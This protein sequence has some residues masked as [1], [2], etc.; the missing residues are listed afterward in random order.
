MQNRLLFTTQKP[1]AIAPETSGGIRRLYTLSLTAKTRSQSRKE[2]FMKNNEP[3][4]VLSAMAAFVRPELK[5]LPTS[6][7]SPI[8]LLAK[9]SQTT[10]R[11]H[12]RLLH[13]TRT[14][15]NANPLNNGQKLDLP[16]PTTPEPSGGLATPTP[17]RIP[18]SRNSYPVGKPRRWTDL[19]RRS[20]TS[21]P[22]S[23]DLPRLG[24]DEAAAQ[25]W[26]HATSNPSPTHR[27]GIT[28]WIPVPNKST[29]LEPISLSASDVCVEAVSCVMDGIPESFLYED[30]KRLIIFDP[31][32]YPG[33]HPVVEGIRPSSIIQ[34]L[35]GRTVKRVYQRSLRIAEQVYI[36]FVSP[37]A[38]QDFLKFSHHL[39]VY[40]RQPQVRIF[41]ADKDPLQIRPRTLL[42]KDVTENQLLAWRERYF[43][44]HS[45]AASVLVDNMPDTDRGKI[46][47]WAKNDR[48]CAFEWA[49]EWR[50][51]ES[52]ASTEKN[53]WVVKDW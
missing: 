22:L 41:E 4:Q 25:V 49:F 8:P 13:C 35:T 47:S 32:K 34:K 44:D 14:L 17:Q 10:M 2:Q 46:I 29:I 12:R 31:T 23:P 9:T 33:G 24:A 19:P 45:G 39:L 26:R 30:I 51:H 42:P 50:L 15:S 27:M 38:L 1:V 52:V 36:R 16:T 28:H 48:Y 43:D 6:R 37:Q 3:A 11:V 5:Y 20:L 53:A 40:G 18:L 7:R 21:N